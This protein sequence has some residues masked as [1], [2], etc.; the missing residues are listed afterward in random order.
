MIGKT[1]LLLAGLA[2]FSLSTT[3]TA[4]HGHGGHGHGGHGGHGHGGHGYGGH[5][6]GGHGHGGWGHVH[7]GHYGGYY[8]HGHFLGHRHY[9]HGHFYGGYPYGWYGYGYGGYPS[10]GYGYYP[11]YYGYSQPYYANAV[12][13]QPQLATTTVEQQ[14][15][16]P[17]QYDC[18][19]QV[20]LPTVDAEVWI[21]GN[22]TQTRGMARNYV[23]TLT[24]AKTQT[25]VVRASWVQNGQTVTDERRL[26]VN[27]GNTALADFTRSAPVEQIPAPN[28]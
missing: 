21:N 20:L 17:P 3:A 1:T 9:G 8:G 6:H 23:A 12:V 4:Q 5:G 25:Y 24:S 14:A 16:P 27:P 18:R 2:V 28:T 15:P 7:G 22:L 10:Y 19:I 11:S 26:E 13:Y